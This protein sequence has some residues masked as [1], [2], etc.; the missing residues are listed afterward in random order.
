MYNIL[1]AVYQESVNIIQS[2][3]LTAPRRAERG[4]NMEDKSLHSYNIKVAQK[5]AM[6]RLRDGEMYEKKFI[7]T[8]I[9]VPIVV[10]GYGEFNIE[11]YEKGFQFPLDTL[12]GEVVVVL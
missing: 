6:E 4:D 3:H 10:A 8:D 1:Q 12:D 11:K 5:L 9:G 2:L 7:D